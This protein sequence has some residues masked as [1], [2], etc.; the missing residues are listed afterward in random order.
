M[1]WLEIVGWVGSLLVIVSLTQARVLRFRVLNLVGAV[2]A[3]AY[4]AIVG[5][6]PFAVMNGVI[7]VIDVYWLVRL[8]RERHDADVY[9]V[10]EVPAD[11]AVL[12]HLL[13]SHASDI[14]RFHPSFA[15]A[16]P[17]PSA[18]FV[19]VRGD[20]LV[21][22]VV[23]RAAG[24]GVGRVDL[25][26]VT[27]RYRDFTPGEFVYRDSGVFAAHGFRRLVVDGRGPAEAHAYL[28]RVGF[29]STT[30]GWQR[31]VAAAA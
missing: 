24:D 3:T 7:A 19:V 12:R 11:D 9:A 1:V 2:I 25:D 4:N 6:W 8:H 30:D 10:L 18:A 28:E 29:R 21:G 13:T 26:Y 5:I 27:P 31:E 15:V 23:V 14:A 17:A 22:A 16:D 20:E